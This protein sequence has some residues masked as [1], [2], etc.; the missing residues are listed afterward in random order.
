MEL[1]DRFALMNVA[2]DQ[3]PYKVN[4]NLEVIWTNVKI[5]YNIGN[6]L[7][8]NHKTTILINI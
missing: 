5:L 1:K 3:S 2:F 4:K 6:N 7:Y 8:T